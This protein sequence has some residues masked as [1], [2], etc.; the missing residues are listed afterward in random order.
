MVDVPNMDRQH[1]KIVDLEKQSLLVDCVEDTVDVKL[2]SK[3][4]DKQLERRASATEVSRTCNS[5]TTAL[6]AVV[7]FFAATWVPM[8]FWA[9]LV[10][11]FIVMM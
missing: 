7:A 2:K 4:P 5:L 1:A 8:V 3:L 9:A 11:G 6:I 10:S